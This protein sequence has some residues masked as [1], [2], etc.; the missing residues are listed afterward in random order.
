MNIL[1]GKES[2]AKRAWR[3]LADNG[4]MFATSTINAINVLGFNSI[5]LF[6]FDIF[7]PNKKC[8]IVERDGRLPILIQTNNYYGI[9]L[10]SLAIFKSKITKM[11]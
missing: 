8:N 5:H 6:G 1:C 4:T 11:V 10:K 2:L 7:I 9:I 3:N